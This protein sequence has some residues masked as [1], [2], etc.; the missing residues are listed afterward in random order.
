MFKIGLSGQMFD[1]VSIW[2]HLYA[3]AE[4]GYE[5][6]EL[7]STH[8]N[9]DVSDAVISEVKKFL[10][11]NNITVNAL[12]CFTGNYGLLDEN[13]AENAFEVFKKYVELADKFE[14]KMIR[15]W[16]AWQESKEADENVW[17][18]AALWMRKSAKYASEHN[19]KIVMEMH[20]GTLCD[21]ADSSLK[22]LEMIGCDNVGLT[23]DPVNLY[24]VPENYTEKTIT[25]LGKH[26]FNVHI[27]DIVELQTDENP[28]CF[29][30]GFYA[31]HIGRFTPVKYEPKDAKRYFEHRRIG[32]GGVDWNGVISALKKIGYEGAI[33][34]ESVDEGNKYMPSKWN[35]AKAC[36]R[37]VKTLVLNIKTNSNWHKKSVDKKGFYHVVS[38]K[39]DETN[40]AEMFRLNLDS[41]DSYELSSDNLEMNV[42]VVKGKIKIDGSTLSDELNH[43]DSFYM[44]GKSKINITAIE[45]CSLYI[46]AAPCD[47]YGKPFVR[48]MDFSLPIGD[49]HQ[50]HGEGSGA[51]EVMFT[52]APQDDASRL[53]CGVTWS[54]DG[55]WTSWKPHQHEKDL[56]EVYCY[57]DIKDDKYGLHYSYNTD[58][59][60]NDA[61]VYVIRN[62]SMVVAPNGY[63]P[64]CAIPGCKNVYFWVLAAHS[65]NSRS[66]ELAITDP[67]M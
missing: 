27:K 57:F 52:L 51:R 22:L 33:I 29:E 56:E 43:L 40:V 41:G 64:T 45:D 21:T 66:Y 63:H 17:N 42:L 37:D 62:G 6:V 23:L 14:A 20:H 11:D 7:R 9:P 46:G 36:Y 12:S 25:K 15:V 28:Y 59:T 18:K 16:S 4:N 39:R 44:P 55:A 5:T 60:F 24:Q 53:I 2:E 50:I 48:K 13:G 67:N 49:I 10:Q 19:K 32:M 61:E 3:A 65:H 58:E 34:V 38:T 35:L 47:G 30:Y 31:K 1:D 54:G 8:I 26:I